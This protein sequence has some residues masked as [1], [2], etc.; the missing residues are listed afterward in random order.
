MRHLVNHK[1]HVGHDLYSLAKSYESTK[2][3]V[4]TSDYW[5]DGVGTHGGGG[6]VNDSPWNDEY[7]LMMLH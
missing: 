4:I 5:S 2:I 3:D 6:G 7:F 1:H